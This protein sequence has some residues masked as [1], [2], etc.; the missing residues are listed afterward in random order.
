MRN[1][2]T[3]LIEGGNVVAK[4]RMTTTIVK[5]VNLI[6]STS[7]NNRKH[8]GVH[9]TSRKPRLENKVTKQGGRLYF[10]FEQKPLFTYVSQTSFETIIS[11]LKCS[12]ND[13]QNRQNDVQNPSSSS[14]FHALHSNTLG[15]QQ[16][17]TCNQVEC[18]HKGHTAVHSMEQVR[19]RELHVTLRPRTYVVVIN[20]EPDEQTK[21]DEYVPQQNEEES[22][23]KGRP[24]GCCNHAKDSDDNVQQGCNLDEYQASSSTWQIR[25]IP[26]PGLVLLEDFI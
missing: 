4:K 14:A 19:I 9:K 26:I 24:L 23:A 18:L 5:T 10:R 6:T 11:H 20:D 8:N 25:Q 22:H 3:R 7:G 1:G 16:N 13:R 12:E 15:K 2:F 17:S 21:E